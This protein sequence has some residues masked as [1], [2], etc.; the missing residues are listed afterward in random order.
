[1]DNLTAIAVS[2]QQYERVHVEDGDAEEEEELL[3]KEISE[4]IGFKSIGSSEDDEIELL[5]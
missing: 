2:E 4:Y 5:V 1:M 3:M